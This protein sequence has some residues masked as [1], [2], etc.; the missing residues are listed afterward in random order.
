MTDQQFL[1][2]AACIWLAP[3]VSKQFAFMGGSAILITA[4]LIGLGVIS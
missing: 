4:S 3:H 2:L 1:V